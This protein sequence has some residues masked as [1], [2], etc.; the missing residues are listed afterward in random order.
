MR[1]ID[2]NG[3][4][5]VCESGIGAALCA[6]AMD[7]I[8]SKLLRSVLDVQQRFDVAA[9]EMAAHRHAADAQCKV[10][11]EL[12]E[13]AFRL[14]AARR[15]VGNKPNA[16]S[17]RRLAACEIDDVAEQP[18]D[19]SAQHV[20]DIELFGYRHVDSASVNHRPFASW[21]DGRA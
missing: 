13:L 11:R 7:Y 21:T 2:A 15:S 1:G 16:M 20:Q 10:R 17:T 18:P 14:F 12:R 4:R 9:A 3:T 6:V 5:Y 8:R 19:R